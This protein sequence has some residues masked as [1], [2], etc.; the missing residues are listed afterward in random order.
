MK[1]LYK[2]ISGI[3]LSACTLLLC[4]SFYVFADEGVSNPSNI[5]YG[6][7]N[8]MV[9]VCCVIIAAAVLAI[10]TVMIVNHVKKK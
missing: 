2:Y 7:E 6:Q 9:T 4:G 10:V 8:I 5:G 3:V 1:G